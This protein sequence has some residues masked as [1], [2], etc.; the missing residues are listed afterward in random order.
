MAVPALHQRLHPVLRG[1]GE[2]L[3][4]QKVIVLKAVV[5]PGGVEDPVA[6]IDQIQQP[7]KFLFTQFDVH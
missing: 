4:L 7:T 1:Q 5:P 6:H 2:H 3:L